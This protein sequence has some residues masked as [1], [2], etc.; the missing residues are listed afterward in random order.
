MTL[1]PT[2]PPQPDHLHALQ[3]LPFELDETADL[4]CLLTLIE[5]WLLH[6]CYAQEALADFV[7]HGRWSFSACVA[8]A[9]DD[10]GRFSVTLLRHVRTSAPEGNAR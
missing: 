1:T 8:Q 3:L 7:F 5:G 9:I 6:D 4:A 10:L 2:P